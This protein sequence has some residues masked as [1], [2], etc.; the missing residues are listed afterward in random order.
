MIK[1]LIELLKAQPQNNEVL[2]SIDSEGNT[3]KEIGESHYIRS[4]NSDS[5]EVYNNKSVIFPN[6]ECWQ[7]EENEKGDLELEKIN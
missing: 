1:E 4:D 3:F 7:Y 6:D 2:L 5:I